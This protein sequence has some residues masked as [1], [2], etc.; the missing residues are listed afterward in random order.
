MSAWLLW[1]L[2]KRVH[3]TGTC[4]VPLLFRADD[5]G[6]LASPARAQPSGLKGPCSCSCTAVLPQHAQR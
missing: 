4:T 5:L 2:V 6:C 3:K 1:F